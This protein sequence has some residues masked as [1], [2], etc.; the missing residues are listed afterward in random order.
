MKTHR[1]VTFFIATLAFLVSGCVSKNP[2]MLGS[3]TEVMAPPP[4]DS[5]QPNLSLGPGGKIYLSWI[6]A[7]ADRQASLK[8]ATKTPQGWSEPQTVAQSYNMFRNYADV[9]SLLELGGGVLA[10][11]WQVSSSD[12]DEGYSV[13]VAMSKDD[14]KTWSAPVTPHRDGKKGE[15]GFV[16]MTSAPGNNAVSVIWLDPRKLKDEEGDVAL[17]RTNISLDG[18]LGEESEIDPRVCECCQPTA[19]PVAGGMLAVYRDRSADEIRDVVVSRFDGSKWSEPKTVFDDKWQIY[20]CPIQGPAIAAAGDN[21]AVAWFTGANDKPK[22]QV[23]LSKD[24]GKTFG[25]PVQIDDGNPIGRVDVVALE[26]GGAVVTWIEHATSGAEIRARQVNP[27]GQKHDAHLVAK[28]TV[29]NAGGF[30]R[31]ERSGNELVFAWT[32]TEAH[33]VRTAIAKP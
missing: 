22:V 28:T 8:F 19:I 9:P 20:A 27:D 7:S 1:T 33:R 2:D 21:I 16:S 13:N 12:A 5:A 29:G 31:V 14:G 10:A 24:G 23:V 4:E 6:E 15:H 17:M 30:P 18:T 32:D 25:V 11:H 26:S 3:I